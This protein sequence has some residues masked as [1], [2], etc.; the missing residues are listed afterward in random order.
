[1]LLAPPVPAGNL[2]V[3]RKRFEGFEG[4]P[5]HNIQL[6]PP[7]PPPRIGRS[8]ATLKIHPAF[9]QYV[10]VS[11]GFV[12]SFIVR[13]LYR[14]I[15]FDLVFAT[16]NLSTF[17]FATFMFHTSSLRYGTHRVFLHFV[18]YLVEATMLMFTLDWAL[19]DTAAG[20]RSGLDYCHR[21]H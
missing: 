2:C 15:P 9:P 8:E 12:L 3:R 11:S 17:P 21:R 6:C 20:A 5:H 19:F 4:A 10:R 13:R 14:C 18:W 16:D 1:M 7:R